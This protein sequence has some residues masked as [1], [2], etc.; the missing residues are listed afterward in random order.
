MGC[1]KQKIKKCEQMLV[2]IVE[3]GLLLEKVFNREIMKD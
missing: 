2:V 1:V 3:E